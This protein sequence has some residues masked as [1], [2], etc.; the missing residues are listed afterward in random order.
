MQFPNNPHSL[1]SPLHGLSSKK[2]FHLKPLKMANQTGPCYNDCPYFVLLMQASVRHNLASCIVT[3]LGS[4]AAAEKYLGYFKMPG[5]NPMDPEK[6]KKLI[7]NAGRAKR[8]SASDVKI[9]NDTIKEG[10]P[11]CQ[12][13]PRNTYQNLF[14]AQPE[15][16]LENYQQVDFTMP[17]PVPNPNS[18]PQ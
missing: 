6:V 16:H 5:W 11:N 7:D 4:F 10:C 17:G 3:S 15:Y 18:Q 2:Y 13:R 14:P 8:K 12:L 1:T 9:I